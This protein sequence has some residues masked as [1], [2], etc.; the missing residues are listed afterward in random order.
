MVWCCSGDDADGVGAAQGVRHRL[1]R[2][3]VIEP[4]AVRD[5][6]VFVAARRESKVLHPS[7]IAERE[8]GRSGRVPFIEGAGNEH[9]GGFG[10]M[11]FETAGAVCG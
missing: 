1:I 5:E 4:L 3:G 9:G 11:E 6:A 8:H 2:V 7:A 10:I